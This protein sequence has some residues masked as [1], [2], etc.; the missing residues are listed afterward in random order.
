M[1]RILGIDPALAQAGWGVIEVSGSSFKFI[2]CGEIKTNAKSPMCE[3]LGVL[4]TS[5]R[6]IMREYDPDEVAIEETF[7]NNNGQSTLKLGQARGAL[8]AGVA[9]EGVPM[10][11][12]A[13]RLVKKALTGNGAADKNQIIAMIKILLPA[14]IVK[15]EDAADALAVAICH[16]NHSS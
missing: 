7:V 14:A 12:Y 1:K 4:A 5:I 2:A 8:I 10:A 6:E 11:E 9:G 3:R 13:A 15:S 16:A